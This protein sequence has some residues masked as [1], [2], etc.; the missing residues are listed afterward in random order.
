MA[1]S[2][3]KKKKSASKKK[4][5]KQSASKKVA[6]KKTVKQNNVSKK[7]SSASAKTKETR[8]TIE[9][10]SNDASS[11]IIALLMA[12]VVAA[13]VIGLVFSGGKDLSKID[14]SAEPSP[15]QGQSSIEVTEP[16]ARTPEST[17]YNLQGSTDQQGQQAGGGLQKPQSGDQLQPNARLDDY[18]NATLEQGE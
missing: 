13:L 12:A 16:S 15:I 2:K 10:K 4:A 9:N 7:E 18:E 1:K 14:S 11:T 17:G 8:V 6:S 5:N 3:S